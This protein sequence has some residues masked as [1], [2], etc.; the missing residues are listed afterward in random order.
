M[1]SQDR[2]GKGSWKMIELG[3][4]N[5]GKYP[6]RES[7]KKTVGN[8]AGKRSWKLT[9][10]THVW[11]MTPKKKRMYAK[12]SR[13]THVWKMTPKTHV[14]KM[15]PKTHVWKMT[16]KTQ[17]FA[18]HSSRLSASVLICCLSCTSVSCGCSLQ[19]KRTAAAGGFWTCEIVARSAPFSAKIR[20]FEPYIR[21]RNDAFLIHKLS[22]FEPQY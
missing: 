14:W 6:E 10:K 18:R 20:V 15:T 17:P 9:A 4:R 21:T 7:W 11:K 2:I 8:W 13:K 22:D 1:L 16:R 5:V 3:K 19:V 12:S